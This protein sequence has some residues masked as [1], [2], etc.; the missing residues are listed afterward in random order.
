MFR[1]TLGFNR[2][3]QTLILVGWRPGLPEG[4][5]RPVFEPLSQ[6]FRGPRHPI[7]PKR[8]SWLQCDAGICCPIYGFFRKADLTN[9]FRENLT[10]K[11]ME[12]T[13][14]VFSVRV[15]EVLRIF[16]SRPNLSP[17]LRPPTVISFYCPLP[18]L[19]FWTMMACFDLLSCL[20]F[21]ALTALMMMIWVLTPCRLVGRHRRFGVTY[22]AHLQPCRRK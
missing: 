16:R 12:V 20:R 14:L 5:L 7:L 8:L 21:E 11:S 22:C 19:L 2:L 18:A 3:G 6:Y 1:I 17:A 10:D 15:I 4:I 9:R 13:F